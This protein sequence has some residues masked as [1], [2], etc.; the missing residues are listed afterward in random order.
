V[1]ALQELP[2]NNDPSIIWVFFQI[3]FNH[4]TYRLT[5]RRNNLYFQVSFFVVLQI[6]VLQL[7]QIY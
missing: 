5:Y 2:L 4:I 6:V 1:L 3:S 7:L